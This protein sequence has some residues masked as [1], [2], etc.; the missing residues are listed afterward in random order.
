MGKKIFVLGCTGQDGS[1][2]CEYLL[3]LGYE[4]HGVIRRSSSF[5][6]QRIEHI[7]SLLKLHY[8]D[9]T[10]PSN[11]SQ[12]VSEIKPNE[13]YFLAA[14][15]HVALSFQIP[16]YTAQVDAIGTLNILEAVKNYCPTSKLYFAGSSELYGGMGFNMPENGYDENSVMYPRSPYA[17]S[18]LFGF[19]MTKNYREAY[20]LFAC[21]GILFNHSSPR[22]PPT[23]L[24]RKVTQWVAKY[25]YNKD[26]EPLEL[27]NLDAWRDE[28]HSFDYVRA[29]HLMLQQDKPDDY[30]V[31]TGTTT[32]IRTW[33]EKCFEYIN[34][35]IE[36]QGNGIDEVGLC[37]G[38]V[39]IKINPKYFRPSEVQRLLGDASKIK[40]LGWKPKY[41]TDMLLSEMMENDLGLEKTS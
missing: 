18:K 2:I 28:G 37:D 22:R 15:S 7:F 20:N 40:A 29:M 11:M 27:G 32:K 35:K 21:N 41:T 36:W 14:Q 13:I 5:N 1:Y 17:V 30:V 3:G 8:G 9:V 26:I 34:K 33:V 12:L 25:N 23:F 24:T 6:T 31:A 39:V 19:W 4:V 10:D 38:K 16:A